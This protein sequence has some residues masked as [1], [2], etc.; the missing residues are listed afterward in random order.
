MTLS[1]RTDCGEGSSRTN[2]KLRMNDTHLRRQHPSSFAAIPVHL[3][4]PAGNPLRQIRLLIPDCAPWLP[5]KATTPLLS[6]LPD[7]I[8]PKFEALFSISRANFSS[9]NSSKRLKDALLAD[10]Y[11]VAFL[12]AVVAILINHIRRTLVPWLGAFMFYHPM[13]DLR[14]ALSNPDVFVDQT[15][16]YSWSWAFFSH[17]QTYL[18]GVLAILTTQVLLLN[19][20]RLPRSTQERFRSSPRA[21]IVS[22]E[23]AMHLCRIATGVYMLMTLD[24]IFCRGTH[25]ISCLIAVSKL[26]AGNKAEHQALSQALVAPWS[27]VPIVALMLWL[28]VRHA[29]VPTFSGA[30]RFAALGRPGLLI[31]LLS[32]AGGV[33]STIRWRARLYILLEMS[34]MFVVLGFLGMTLVLLAKEFVSDSPGLNSS[35][36]GLNRQA[37][38]AGKAMSS[39]NVAENSTS[40]GHHNYERGDYKKQKTTNAPGRHDMKRS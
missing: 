3:Y 16:S 36:V 10:G 6:W 33:A 2:D 18:F 1:D 39:R 14:L 38:E 4:L 32:A 40:Q 11:R 23:G 24:Y 20:G 22:L 17:L 9:Q 8:L 34:P 19:N 29:L 25:T 37:R 5:R 21:V 13:D 15:L 27:K 12:Q 35:P 7:S 30:L 31:T 26:L 28:Y